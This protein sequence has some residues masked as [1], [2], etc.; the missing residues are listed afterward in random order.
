MMR[1]RRDG[2]W[3]AGRGIAG[4]GIVILGRRLRK[5]DGESPGLF[6]TPSSGFGLNVRTVGS[7]MDLSI[8]SASSAD[9][10][11]WWSSNACELRRF[12][13]CVPAAGL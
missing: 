3:N 7:H 12:G 13:I 8:L 1:S 2:R 9:A 4:Q 5:V 11:L 6:G 10:F